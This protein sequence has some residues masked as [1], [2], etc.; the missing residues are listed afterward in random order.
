MAPTSQ[1]PDTVADCPKMD[2][3]AMTDVSG[4]GA[5]GRP[6]TS[7]LSNRDLDAL[8]WRAVYAERSKVELTAEVAEERLAFRK[9]LGYLERENEKLKRLLRDASTRL[10]SMRHALEGQEQE[11]EKAISLGKSD[12]DAEMQRYLV[13]MKRIEN[14]A[15]PPV[16]HASSAP[17]GI[18]SDVSAQQAE[19]QVEGAREEWLDTKARDA[20]DPLESKEEMPSVQA[21][22]ASMSKGDTSQNQSRCCVI[23]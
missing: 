12:E 4:S 1:A 9:R 19:L 8:Y 15:A 13:A 6:D 21:Q 20:A 7:K 3:S 18:P 10:K 14:V 16:A 17:T 11:I 23:S 5:Q 22:P 2:G